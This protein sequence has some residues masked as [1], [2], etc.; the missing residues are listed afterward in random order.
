MSGQWGF[1][2]NRHAQ[3]KVP[4]PNKSALAAIGCN[5]GSFTYVTPTAVQHVCTEAV[6]PVAAQPL[7]KMQGM[8]FVR[9]GR[10]LHTFA[11]C[12]LEDTVVHAPCKIEG[13]AITVSQR[14]QGMEVCSGL[15][16]GH[17][18][19]LPACCAAPFLLQAGSLHNLPADSSRGTGPSCASVLS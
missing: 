12:Y 16:L 17:F 18:T 8:L 10:L 2:R 13:T 7:S 6:E 14:W 3:W 11:P 5:P 1:R 9:E 15:G 19:L 4:A